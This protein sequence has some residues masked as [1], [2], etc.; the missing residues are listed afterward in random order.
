MTWAFVGA[1]GGIRTPNLLIRT[2]GRHTRRRARVRYAE[3]FRVRFRL[4]E[5]VD[6]QPRCC[7]LL[8]YRRLR[9]GDDT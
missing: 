4:L 5:S 3:A 7:T 9:L 8:L 6:I 2:I 1:L